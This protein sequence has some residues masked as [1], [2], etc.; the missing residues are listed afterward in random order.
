M[1]ADSGLDRR[2]EQ[3]DTYTCSLHRLPSSDDPYTELPP[4]HRRRRHRHDH[5]GHAGQVDERHRPR[6]SWTSSRRS[7]P[8]SPAMP[9][10]RARSS[11]RA[12]TPSPAAPTSTCWRRCSASS[13]AARR[14]RLDREAA[15]KRLFD[16]SSRLGRIFRRLETCGKPVVA[17]INGTALGGAFEL[18]LACHGRIVADDPKIKLGLPGGEGRADPRR[19]RHAA[20]RAARQYRRTRCRCCFAASSS[21]RPAPRR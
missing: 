21:R 4:R 10:S 16:E 19:R 3:L 17:A 5:L 6:R 8:R 2:H 15:V 13:H 9:R 11:P 14:R 18:A 7:S 12:R 1:V 20:R